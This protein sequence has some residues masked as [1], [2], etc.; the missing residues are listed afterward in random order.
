ME[1]L[2][3]YLK[4][5]KS[6]FKY[7]LLF[8]L[9]GSFLFLSGCQFDKE[10]DDKVYKIA[11]NQVKTLNPFLVTN[12]DEKTI[13]NLIY[14]SLFSM[15]KNTD[16]FEPFI[17]KKFII[18]EDKVK[19]EIKKNY[20][21]SNEN[22]IDTDFLIKYFNYFK[23]KI[24]D[25]ENSLIPDIKNLIIE[26]DEDYLIIKFDQQSS[27][28]N[29]MQ[30]I[31][32]LFT[33]PILSPQIFEKIEKKPDLYYKY[34]SVDYMEL[35]VI[36][37]GRWKIKSN[38]SEF[39]EL[40]KNILKGK[41]QN[42]YKS[43]RF[44]I[45]KDNNIILQK[46]INK[47]VDICF[48]DFN[49]YNFLKKFS[50]VGSIEV[51]DPE[52]FYVLFFNYQT[53]N[54]ENKKYINDIN[55]RRYLFSLIY[56]KIKENKYITAYQ[57]IYKSFGRNKFDN[58]EKELVF[59]LFSISD[60]LTSKIFMEKVVEILNKNNIRVN[61]YNENLNNMIARIYATKNWDF[62][63]TNLSIDY[64]FLIDFELYNPY[65]FQHIFNINIDNNIDLVL[66]F[67]NEIYNFIEANYQYILKNPAKI[68]KEIEYLILKNYLFI[69]LAQNNFFIFF[70]KKININ[71]VKILDKGFYIEKIFD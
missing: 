42:K 6:I 52:F 16:N 17:A 54:I 18:Y 30:K 56:N 23:K 63:I 32:H 36:S 35:P 62:F 66:P 58:I 27:Y 5:I 11:V 34:G 43:L 33:F 64:P 68:Y 26:K 69:P 1:R 55:F 50:K 60:D 13:V 29:N 39:I 38:N 7:F 67:E 47:E 8:F 44:E 45:I 57:N 49:D 41:N 65:S 71:K 2:T 51:Y 22:L 3:E 31:G 53:A 70:N 40:E 59:Y 21:D 4:L 15:Y 28:I 19:I 25:D 37:T 14:G 10:M 48:G 20:L 46:L 12:K 9:L 61:G 24:I